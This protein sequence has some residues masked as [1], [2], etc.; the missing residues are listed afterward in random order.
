MNDRFSVG[1]EAVTPV[2]QLE[3]D[4]D[5]SRSVDSNTAIQSSSDLTHHDLVWAEWEQNNSSILT[6]TFF[7][8]FVTH[9]TCCHCGHTVAHYAPYN[10]ISLP[11]PHATDRHVVV[12]WI[13][14]SD[15]KAYRF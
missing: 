10:H 6:D 5:C 9:T 7:G 13:P 15:H 14:N 4:E 11:L 3:G 1:T 8:Q 12:T 2:F